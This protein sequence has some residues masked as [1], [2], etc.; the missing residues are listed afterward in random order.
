MSGCLYF[1]EKLGGIK[2]HL[3][4]Y[5]ISCKTFFFQIKDIFQRKH[6][7]IANPLILK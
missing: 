4:K 3:H 1:S 7:F 2:D 5:I 6:E